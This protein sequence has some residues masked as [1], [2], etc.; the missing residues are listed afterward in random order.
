MTRIKFIF[1][2]PENMT[3]S[4]W[5]IPDLRRFA[6]YLS[7]AML[8]TYSA[9]GQPTQ[10]QT[11]VQKLVQNPKL[12]GAHV[13]IAVMNMKTGKV[14]ASH[15]E[16]KLFIPASTLKLV[17]TAAAVELLKPDFTF[18]TELILEGNVKDGQVNG[19]III[20]GFGDPSLGSEL[21][22]TKGKFQ[23]WLGECTDILLRNGIQSIQGQLLADESYLPIPPEQATWQWMDLGNYYAGGSWA[24]NA[25]EN[26]FYITFQQTTQLGKT[27]EIVKIEPEVPGLVLKNELTTAAAS[28]GDNAYVYGAPFQDNRIIRGTIPAG[29]GLFTIKASLPHPAKFLLYHL[30]KQLESKGISLK[31]ERI[32]LEKEARKTLHVWQSP[33]LIQLVDFANKESSNLICESLYHQLGKIGKEGVQK[34]DGTVTLS[35]W[36]AQKL[37]DKMPF[38]MEDGS[39]L[40]MK[41]GLSPSLFVRLL[42]QMQFS[43]AYPAWKNTIPIAGREGTVKSLAKQVTQAKF[44]LKSGSLARVRCYAG[45]M[46]KNDGQ[47][48]ALCI[49]LNQHGLSSSEV[50]ALVDS[51]LA[52]I[53]L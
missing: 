8:A 21:L 7:F 35:D 53:A 48:F 28:T 12:K 5:Q 11:A 1:K 4:H 37:A 40:S 34:Y 24:I 43:P 10:M 14:V 41:N 18:K 27:P 52:Q 26:M 25:H 13:G 51:F 36:L 15:Q 9:S 31:G 30:K 44:R 38:F 19:N 6:W 33:P 47:Q 42:H 32:L 50:R 39:G 17:T 29:T 20:K 45:Y 23:E 49:M 46:E 22:Y 2:V 16:D 3:L